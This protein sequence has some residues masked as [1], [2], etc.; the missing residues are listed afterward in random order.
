MALRWTN[1]DGST[2]RV[3]RAVTQDTQRR[4]IIGPTKTGRNRAV[5]LGERAMRA[6]H[7]HK[8]AQAKWKLLTG[9]ESRTKA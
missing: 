4:K 6:I 9:E 8:V 3:Q 7:R 1:L 5:P 2:L